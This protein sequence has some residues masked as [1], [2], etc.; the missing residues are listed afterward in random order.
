[1]EASSITVFLLL[2]YSCQCSE[3]YVLPMNNNTDCPNGSVCN[4]LNYYASQSQ[5]Y[6]SSN[7]ILTF[8]EGTHILEQDG[9][10]IMNGVTNITLRG[11]GM[12]ESIIN[13]NKS[14]SGLLLYDFNDITF[15]GLT[16]TDCG[17]QLP[18]DMKS[19]ITLR[20]NV[21][22]LNW[23]YVSS[24]NASFSILMFNG[25]NVTINEITLQDGTGYGLMAVNV[26]N[27]VI[28]SSIFT[29]N[30]FNCSFTYSTYS[31][32]G[33]I[34]FA[35]IDST[36]CPSGINSNQSTVSINNVSVMK[37]KNCGFYH[38]T[39]YKAYEFAGRGAGLTVFGMSLSCSDVRFDVNTVNA[40]HNLAYFGPNILIMGLP[41]AFNI[42]KLN[43]SY[44][45][46][47]VGFGSGSGSI[48]LGN[49][50]TVFL[51]ITPPDG[52]SSELTITNGTFIG[53]EYGYGVAVSL[54]AYSFKFYKLV[55]L[56][57]CY[58]S[59]NKGFTILQF[60]KISFVNTEPLRVN[61]K[62]VQ[63]DRNGGNITSILN[64]AGGVVLVN[65]DCHASGLTVS[66]GPITG[67]QMLGSTIMFTGENII[68][69]NSFTNGGGMVLL[70]DSTIIFQPPSVLNFIN[71]H[72][73]ELGGAIYIPVNTE[74]T[75]VSPCFFQI[76]DSPL[77]L[78]VIINAINNTATITGSFISGGDLSV[79]YLFGNRTNQY[80]TKRRASYNNFVSLIQPTV[81]R[82]DHLF[83]SST[84]VSVAV[85]NSNDDFCF[86]PD[87]FDPVF[88]GRTVN[89]S[90]ATLGDTSGFAPGAITITT[91][92]CT[93][94]KCIDPVE[95]YSSPY[96][97]DT[98][99]GT[100]PIVLTGNKY[101][102][103]FRVTVKT[104]KIVSYLP[105]RGLNLY[106]P[107]A[108]CPPGFS[109]SEYCDC[110]KYIE[111]VG[112]M[113]DINTTTITTNGS[114]W[115]GY[116][117]TSNCTLYSDECLDDYCK[118][119]DVTFNIFQPDLQ[120]AYNRAGILCGECIEGYSILLGSNECGHCPN[121]NYLSLLIVFS[122]A[123]ILL[124][125]LLITLNLTVSVGTINGLI[126]YANIVKINEDI[127][128]PSNSFDPPILRQF[129][130]FINLDFGLKA[131]FVNGLTAY[132]KAWLQFVFPLYI[133]FIMIVI[134]LLSRRF[135]KLS[136]L[137]GN[138]AVKVFATLL[139]L[140]Y[141]KIIRA[142]GFTLAS[143]Y[144]HCDTDRHHVW[145]YDGNVP[146]GSTKHAI[147]MAFSILF[148]VCLVLPYTVLM[149]GLP[150]VDR[151]FSLI[152]CRRCFLWLKPFT[153]AYSGPFK[154]YH[155][156]WAGLLII[157][158]IVLTVVKNII[159]EGDISL[160]LTAFM[161]MILL[162]LGLDFQGPYQKI[163]LNVLESWFLINLFGLSIL[164]LKNDDTAKV[165]AIISVSLVLVT[166]VGLVIYHIYWLY[167]AS[168][169]E[170][171]NAM[172]KERRTRNDDLDASVSS[173]GTEPLI[174]ACDLDNGKKSNQTAAA[175]ASN[176][177][178]S[179]LSGS[180]NSRA[181][182]KYTSSNVI[183]SSN[184]RTASFSRY[185]D[186]IFDDLDSNN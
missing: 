125:V 50:L 157:A 137:I 52:Y 98:L 156:F 3:Y 66:N 23:E 73:D 70:S 165:S 128:F 38:Q 68:E 176:E 78:D 127:F 163:T 101:T 169:F 151:F 174:N 4:D 90:I 12:K 59:E 91:Y 18:Q 65:C 129:I 181:K 141:T 67:I 86:Y 139:L 115:I 37:G 118:Q 168:I 15:F 177:S 172:Y 142:I 132:I 62:N 180:D 146:Y 164:S 13:C 170:K 97:T 102:K 96:T 63:L 154:Q 155:T 103:W 126:F 95:L 48:G 113:C 147:L 41:I 54:L 175:I 34:A 122:I 179:K 133:W 49:G 114:V 167:L 44:G 51:T 162:A 136:K 149:V 186:S 144:V 22:R 135:T 173:I 94:N 72:A 58:V 77:S 140:S 69:N 120:C 117:N 10:I 24:V 47:I 93:N 153:D 26:Y 2:L 161:V 80:S 64:F 105:S 106:F 32:G 29:G 119:Q 124:V 76:S 75:Y 25:T 92:N 31:Q 108:D 178:G 40:T 131:C 35:Y 8:L 61:L 57:S 28:M 182:Y 60:E 148:L 143:D 100:I 45:R 159:T 112:G 17:F 134:M 150:V 130:S 53:N 89:V 71:N 33:N 19:Y 184:T 36:Q 166:F 7:T 87:P 21:T 81:N 42:N 55:S 82:N 30:N 79:C 27:V 88:Q 158:R 111:S 20:Y 99:C 104:S 56:E 109:K 185:R 85:C 1:M 123:G 6:F 14:N 145:K 5:I 46:G 110:N 84:P 138:N 43:C 11:E 183:L 121:N 160:L 74:R 171:M 83:I 152:R 9:P 39:E 107:S 116:D 16:I